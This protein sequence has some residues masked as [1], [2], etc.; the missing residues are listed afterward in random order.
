MQLVNVTLRRLGHH[1]KRLHDVFPDMS[2]VMKYTDQGPHPGNHWFW[3]DGRRNHGHDAKGQAYLRWK[4]RPTADSGYLTHGE[5]NVA[6]LHIAAVRGAPKGS[7]FEN[8]CGLSQCINPAHWRRVD[9]PTP[10]RVQVL[11]TGLWQLVRVATGHPA[12]RTVVVHAKLGDVVHL[13]AIAPLV[14]RSFAPPRAMC[15]TELPPELLVVTAS[16]PTCGA[17][18]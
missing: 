13:V 3:R 11:G 8:T 16:P 15:G 1:R 14:Q 5:F 10:W 2:Y 9:P 4:V 18:V 7:A 12:Q 6:R 17:C